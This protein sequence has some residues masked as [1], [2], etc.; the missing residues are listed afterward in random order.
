MPLTGVADSFTVV[1]ILA[2]R[3]LEAAEAT[4]RY[5]LVGGTV[6]TLVN[7]PVTVAY[8]FAAALLPR[9]AGAANREKA[10]RE[11]AFSVRLAFVF[12]IRIGDLRYFRSRYNRNSVPVA[13]RFHKNLTTTLLRAE[14][15]P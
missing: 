15:P 9:V 1:N 6:S 13:V 10:N 14:A 5:G 2:A 4:A 3:G 8:A 7:L 12:R 11:I